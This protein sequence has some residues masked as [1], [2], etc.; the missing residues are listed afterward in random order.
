MITKLSRFIIKESIYVL[1]NSA[2]HA[3]YRIFPP[4]GASIDYFEKMDHK[5]SYP[6]HYCL[7]LSEL[8]SIYFFW[9]LMKIYKVKKTT[10][11]HHPS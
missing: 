4:L 9:I 2:R 7:L 1:K 11:I 6:P 8:T 10:Y 3:S 5:S